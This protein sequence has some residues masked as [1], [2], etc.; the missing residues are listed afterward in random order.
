MDCSVFMKLGEQTDQADRDPRASALPV[1]HQLRVDD[2]AEARSEGLRYDSLTGLANRSLFATWIA[3]AASK[4]T[5]EQPLTLVAIDIDGFKELNAALGTAVGDQILLEVARRIEISAGASARVARIGGDEF[6]MVADQGRSYQSG[7]ALARRALALIDE[8]LRLP[9]LDL[10][11]SAS[12]GIAETVD[13]VSSPLDALS[14]AEVARGMARGTRQRMQRYSEAL[15][16]GSKRRLTLASDLRY[17]IEEGLLEVW[18]QPVARMSD[19]HVTGI[20]ALTRWLD[21]ERGAVPPAEFIPVA[22]EDGTIAGLTSWVLQKALK[23][24]ERLRSRGYDL[25]V[26]VNLSPGLLYD[27]DVMTAILPALE[28]H[29]VPAGRLSLEVTETALLADSESAGSTLGE[30][31]KR[32]VHVAIDDFG[33]GFSSLARLGDLPVDTI[34]LDRSFVSQ[35]TAGGS[36]VAL[37]K[38][39]LDLGRS[40]GHRVVAEGVERVDTW[41]ALRA[42]GCDLLQGYVISPARPLSEIEEWFGSH[43][44]GARVLA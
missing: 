2:P 16:A 30:L 9:A 15:L 29:A 44:G 36:E 7:E 14:K 25:T 18:Y 43:P 32:G 10:R 12:A 11:L 28:S 37:V 4:A 31:A 38:A 35:V 26:A 42:L 13:T 41:D 5:S 21:A 17:A 24:L 34:K 3:D 33:T 6:A 39:I 23:D 27:S 19:G 22:E 1:R 8:P 20:E 40:L